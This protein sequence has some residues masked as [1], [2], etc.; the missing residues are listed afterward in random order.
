VI[1][2]LAAGS[3]SIPVVDQ[4]DVYFSS[5]TFCAS[6]CHE[7]ESTVYK[8]LQSSTHWTTSTGV[9]PSCADCHVSERL[10]PAMWDHFLGM[11]ELIAHLTSDASKPGNFDKKF[12]ADSANR[13]RLKM[14]ANDSK[15]CRSCHEMTAIKPKRKRGQKL[16]AEA[17]E[18]KATCITCHYNLVHKEVEPSD[19]FLKAIERN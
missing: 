3:I 16:H 13:V 18:N 10:V 12:R 7:M 1:G 9:R 5:N 17:L 8:E 14:F 11:K 19:E 6:A 4:V 2:A 15:N